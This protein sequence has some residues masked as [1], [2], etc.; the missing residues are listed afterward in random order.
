VESGQAARAL[1]LDPSELKKDFWQYRPGR[2]FLGRSVEGDE[3]GIADNR[4]LLTMA[5]SRAGKG[6]STIIPNLLRYEGSVLVLDP[7]GENARKTA[8][9]R[10][11]MGQEVHVLDPFGKSGAPTEFLSGFN[12]IAS[13]RADSPEFI[14]DCDAL[15]DAV[16]MTESGK[17]DDFWSSAS[18]IVLRG[19][20]AW[21]ASYRKLPKEERHFGMVRDLLVLPRKSFIELLEGMQGLPLVGAGLPAES[22]SFLLGLEDRERGS[23]MATVLTNIAFL[24][25]PS[26]RR[27]FEG[28]GR[29]VDLKTW[30]FGGV[31]IFLCL[32]AMR[33]Q[34][35]ARFLR[36]Y[37]TSLMLAVE[38]NSKEPDIPALL[39]LDE[40]HVLGRMPALEMAAGL[41]AGYGV[42]I[43]SIW[44]DMAQ[45]KSIYRDRWE[46]FLGNASVF[47][48]FGLNDHGG[49]SYVS[50]RLGVSP[51]MQVSQSEISR[52]Q[53]AGG[54]T[55]KSKSLQAGPLLTPDEVAYFF[56]RQ[57]KN[58]LVLY[59]GADPIFLKR[60]EYF[61]D[62]TFAGIRKDE[63]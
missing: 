44:Q 30:K 53:A 10:A 41:V 39:L 2:I 32:P 4:H 62:S 7:K 35:H 3:V 49:L 9:R 43:W 48:S 46:T 28:S 38:A 6:V 23:V 31:S 50:E 1:W 37:V 21:V 18:R 59:P 14:D 12:P 36:A 61:K 47:Q 22:A 13:L 15:A 56:S 24:A 29:T 40:M 19:F 60:V 45:L 58:Q 20:I 26:M 11:Q 8:E 52:D 27:M 42:R 55:G 34:R 17:E 5:G 63:E 54:F 25:S 33:L 51:T 16:V 57:S